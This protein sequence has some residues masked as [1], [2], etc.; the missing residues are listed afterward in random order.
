MDCVVRLDVGLHVETYVEPGTSIRRFGWLLRAPDSPDYLSS[1]TF[2]TRREAMK[3]SEL[4]VDRARQR[5]R[6]RP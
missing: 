1:Q 4:A 2:A 6:L 3:D 5:G